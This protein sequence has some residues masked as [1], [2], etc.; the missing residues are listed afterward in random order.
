MKF[1]VYI[2]EC[3]D[4]TYYTGCTNNLEKRI[5]EHNTSKKGAKYTRMRRPVILKHTETFATLGEARAREA[6]IKQLKRKEK[7]T[8]V[9]NK[10]L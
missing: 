3:S 2:L 9:H 10:N 8:L 7:V 6:E 4:T 5:R 1:F